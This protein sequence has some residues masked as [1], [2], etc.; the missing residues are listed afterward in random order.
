MNEQYK[1]AP[2]ENIR[3]AFYAYCDIIIRHGKGKEGSPLSS[4]YIG[5]VILNSIACEIGLKALLAYENNFS[6]GH[7]LYELFYK[8][9]PQTQTTIKQYISYEEDSFDEALLESKNNFI[10]WRYYYESTHLTVNYEFIFR[11]FSA[12]KAILDMTKPEA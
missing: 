5:C 10:K 7:D 4:F 2:F 1:T 9:S 8:L 3:E 6:H 11:L 12:I